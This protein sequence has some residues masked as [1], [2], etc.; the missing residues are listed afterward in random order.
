M[1]CPNATYKIV[2]QLLHRSC[3]L[4]IT[5][6]KKNLFLQCKVIMGVYSGQPVLGCQLL[7]TSNKKSEHQKQQLGSEDWEKRRCP[8]PPPIPSLSDFPVFLPQ[9]VC[10]LFLITESPK[11]ANHYRLLENS[12]LISKLSLNQLPHHYFLFTSQKPVDH[13]FAWGLTW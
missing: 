9:L 8:C 10:L 5:V 11:Q 13:L 7:G 2:F 4:K 3:G 6:W 1:V 12:L